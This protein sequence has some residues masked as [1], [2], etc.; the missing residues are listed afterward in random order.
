MDKVY[1]S[2][3][4]YEV[5]ARDGKIYLEDTKTQTIYLCKEIIKGE[6]K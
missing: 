2:K 6:L 4:C 3:E 5:Y 1:I